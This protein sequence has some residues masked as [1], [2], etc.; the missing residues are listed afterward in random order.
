MGLLLHKQGVGHELTR[1]Q[2]EHNRL[3]S[4]DRT[5]GENFFGPWK[6]L[7]ESCEG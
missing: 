2:K 7:F 3:P 4:Q 6:S 1:E 5:L